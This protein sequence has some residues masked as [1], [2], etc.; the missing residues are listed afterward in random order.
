[1]DYCC[2]NSYNCYN[3]YNGYTGCNVYNATSATTAT[4]FIMVTIMIKVSMF[5]TAQFDAFLICSNM[6]RNLVAKCLREVRDK[7]CLAEYLQV[8]GNG[9]NTNG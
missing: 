6:S 9:P 7:S 1:M 5:H 3:R 8:T 2:Y 4:M